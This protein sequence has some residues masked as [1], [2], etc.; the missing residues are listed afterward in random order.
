MGQI[1]KRRRAQPIL[2][3]GVTDHVP[4][5]FRFPP[6]VSVA[7]SME[8]VKANSSRWVRQRRREFCWQTGHTAFSVSESNVAEVRQYVANQEEHHRNLLAE[9]FQRAYHCCLIFIPIRASGMIVKVE[10]SLAP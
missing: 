3:N 10:K 8:N 1:L 5:W 6:S 9:N 7:D 2:I 4:R